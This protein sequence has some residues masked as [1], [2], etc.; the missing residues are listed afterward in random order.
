MRESDSRA[1][2]QAMTADRNISILHASSRY[3]IRQSL[4]ISN[5]SW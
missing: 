1:Q 5:T 4:D 2:S 3:E